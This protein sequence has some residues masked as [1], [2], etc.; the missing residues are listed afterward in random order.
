[1]LTWPSQSPDL[2]PIENLWGYLK[3]KIQEMIPKSLKELEQCLNQEWNVIPK[4]LCQKL[5][6]SFRKRALAVCRAKG[7]HD[8]Y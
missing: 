1:M 8:D 3:V 5:A 4:D 2:N 6:L 7:N